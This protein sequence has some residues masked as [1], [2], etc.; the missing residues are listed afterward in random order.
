M[1]TANYVVPSS[2]ADMACETKE[3]EVTEIELQK[4]AASRALHD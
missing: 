1:K 3:F 4:Q 2:G